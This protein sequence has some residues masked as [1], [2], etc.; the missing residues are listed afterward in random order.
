MNNIVYCTFPL[1]IDGERI[2]EIMRKE[3][4]LVEAI[5]NY[6]SK[7]KQEDNI[8]TFSQFD[9]IIATEDGY[10]GAFYASNVIYTEEGNKPAPGT[11][12]ESDQEFVAWFRDKLGTPK[13]AKVDILN[14]L[15]NKTED[16]R[17]AWQ[18]KGDRSFFGGVEFFASFGNYSVQ[19]RRGYPVSL[20]DRYW[21]GICSVDL[22]DKV[23]NNGFI[24]PD[25]EDYVVIEPMRGI[26][27]LVEAIIA[28][29]FDNIKPATN[30]HELDNIAEEL[31]NIK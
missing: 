20:E 17:I 1:D 19:I 28:L 24:P 10:Y 16:G 14:I 23:I 11:E 21:M 13:A 12:Y 3:E 31:E 9:N 4:E 2:H 15:R 6:S 27:K 8:E 25:P 26:D 30:F 7:L 5:D 29:Q 22:H 18:A